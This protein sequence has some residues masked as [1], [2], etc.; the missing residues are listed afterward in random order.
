[1][2]VKLIVSVKT[3]PTKS[4]FGVPFEAA[5]VYGAGIIITKFLMSLELGVGEELMFVSE[6][7]L[8]PCA[9]IAS[10]CQLLV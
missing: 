2:C 6:D 8:V 4:T 7:F 5:L 9:K 10:S 3:L 1:M